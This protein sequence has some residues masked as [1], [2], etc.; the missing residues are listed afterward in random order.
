MSKN[1]NVEVEQYYDSLRDVNT[2]IK[3]LINRDNNTITCIFVENM[4]PFIQ[5][6]WKRL[7]SSCGNRNYCLYSLAEV[8]E[9]AGIHNVDCCND[10]RYEFVGISKCDPRDRFNEYYGK[11]LAFNRA[12]TEIFNFK[13]ECINN[14]K[15]NLSNNILRMTETEDTLRKKHLK[16]SKKVSE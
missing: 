2:S 14:I 8:Y 12:K 16:A 13:I 4:A 11:R 9:L 5:K 3:Y 10:C 15:K 1:I 6:L 7:Y